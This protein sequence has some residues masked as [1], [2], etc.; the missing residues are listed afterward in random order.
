MPKRPSRKTGAVRNPDR[1]NGKRWTSKRYDDKG[2]ALTGRGKPSG[3]SVRGMRVDR[4]SDAWR[5]EHDA[6]FAG[7]VARWNSSLPDST[8]AA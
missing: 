7:A 3:R 4:G 8:N 2:R 6:G 5:P 1:R